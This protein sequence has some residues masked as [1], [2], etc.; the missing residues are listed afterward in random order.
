MPDVE[1]FPERRSNPELRAIFPAA[2]ELLRPFF[3]PRNR[4]H[5]QAHDHLALHALKDH[6]PPNLSAQDIYLIMTTAR[7]LFAS[8][9]YPPIPP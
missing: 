1:P 9:S 6:F 4:W 5:G 7:R 3:E 2:C 8:G